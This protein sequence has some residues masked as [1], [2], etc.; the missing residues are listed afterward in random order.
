MNVMKLSIFALFL[1]LIS[2]CATTGDS[3]PQKYG[4]KESQQNLG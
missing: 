1:M 4:I 2:A 3:D